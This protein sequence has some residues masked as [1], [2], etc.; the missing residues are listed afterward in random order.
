MG[1]PNSRVRESLHG[2]RLPPA[3]SSGTMV[4]EVDQY[5][6]DGMIALSEEEILREEQRAYEIRTCNI[7]HRMLTV[8]GHVHNNLVRSEADLLKIA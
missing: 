1:V 4:N 2:T 8:V 3:G 6:E 7:T 5:D